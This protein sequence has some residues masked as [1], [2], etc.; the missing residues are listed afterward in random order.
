MEAI[1]DEETP[2]MK[3]S[4]LCPA[5]RLTLH[6]RRG[7]RG[8]G[9][10]AVAGLV[11]SAG[12][13]QAAG[14]VDLPSAGEKV[15]KRCNPRN[16][17]DNDRCRVASLPGE[18]GYTLKS[19]RSVPIVINDVTVGTLDDRVWKASGDQHIFGMRVR[20]NAAAYDL[21]GLSLNVNDLFRQILAA[22][23][24]AIAYT[25]GSSLATKALK[26]SGRTLQ[27]LNELPPEEDDEE[28]EGGTEAAAAAADY[29][30]PEQPVRNNGWVDFRVDANAAEVSG[31]SSAYSPWVLVKT[32]APAGYAVKSFAVR[33][34]SSD[35][36]DVS[37]HL[38]VYLS[39]YQPN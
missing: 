17:A 34:L 7:A 27:G 37:E 23:P 3:L 1:E 26:R 28:A 31:P 29:T 24:A 16:V 6:A 25:P 15:M 35:F 39:G 2:S 13:A 21:T 10:A 8:I 38:N 12:A 14:Y 30:G 5:E 20:L 18:S 33:V 22:Q 11:L 19:S 36:D 4:I 32:K 9:L